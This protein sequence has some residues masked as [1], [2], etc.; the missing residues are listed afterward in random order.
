M[1]LVVTHKPT[2][3]LQYVLDFISNMVEGLEVEIVSF[4]VFHSR[5]TEL[6]ITYGTGSSKLNNSLFH[7]SSCGLLE[8]EGINYNLNKEWNET[9]D[10]FK[11]ALVHNEV[12]VFASIF[13]LLSRLEE[14]QDSELDQIGRY[15]SENSALC[16]ANVHHKPWVDIWAKAFI[17]KLDDALGSQLIKTIKSR[18]EPTMDIDI[19]FEY[20]GRNLKRTLGG[21]IRDIKSPKRLLER[22]QVYLG[23]KKDPSYIF[24]TLPKGVTYFVHVGEEGPLDKNCGLSRKDFQAFLQHEKSESVGL[25]PSFHSHLD[26]DELIFELEQLEVISDLQ[27]SKTRQHYIKIKLPYTYELLEELGMEKDY[28]MGWPDI[29]GYRVGTNYPYYFFN[30]KTNEQSKLKIQPFAWM[31]THFIFH[32]ADLAQM[33]KQ[34]YKYWNDVIEYGGVFTP[35]FHNNH[36]QQ[37]PNNY[38]LLE[39]LCKQG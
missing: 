37:H 34:F 1:I 12:D 28:S 31:D 32:K 7:I 18:V 6:F 13:F 33:E 2:K 21:T 24:N 38:K 36:F 26:I 27:I 10:S 35:I 19:A 5:K 30:L 3:R 39:E 16:K 9:Y 29:P 17:S 20:L 15:K 11:F 8:E 25:H 22:F 14:Y 4:E 23:L